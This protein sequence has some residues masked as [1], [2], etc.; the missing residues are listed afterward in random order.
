MSVESEYI[1]QQ[2]TALGFS[3]RPGYD[4]SSVTFY[5]DFAS[6]HEVARLHVFFDKPV[7]GQPG[8][9][10][11]SFI[12]TTQRAFGLDDAGSAPEV[13]QD[14]LQVLAQ[15]FGHLGNYVPEQSLSTRDCVSC[16]KPVTTYFVVNTDAIC[17]ACVHARR[18]QQH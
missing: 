3:P 15:A 16:K 5:K 8:M 2:M 13:M 11:G 4:A 10:L 6:G 12:V 7:L 18:S 1:V 14:D 17:H 9:R